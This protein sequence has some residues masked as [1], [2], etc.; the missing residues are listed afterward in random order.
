MSTIEIIAVVFSLLCLALSVRRN[1][2]N[3]PAGIVGVCAYAILFYREKLY[4]DLVLQGFFF[5]QGIYGW[6]MW[7]KSKQQDAD[8]LISTLP[9]HERLMHVLAIVVITG[10]W[11]FALMKFTDASLPFVDAFAAATSFT[12]NWLMARRKIESWILWITADVVYIGLFGYKEL[13]LS[14]GI[15]IVFL[16]MAVAGLLEWRR[17]SLSM[18]SR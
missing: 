11:A 13:Y 8:I 17:K 18:A 9:I 5:V 15:Y 1:V 10:S 14:S 12:A 2:L 7:K 3:W 6:T 16:I 4:A